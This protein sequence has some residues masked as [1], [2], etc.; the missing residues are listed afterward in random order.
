MKCLYC[1][2]NLKG[3][4]CNINGSGLVHVFEES[5]YQ[6][7]LDI[8]YNNNFDDILTFENNRVNNFWNVSIANH[9]TKI[10]L[11]KRIKLKSIK[12]INKQEID[13]IISLVMLLK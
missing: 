3:N 5:I 9:Q 7:Y 4:T 2:K 12:S 10:G 6:T 13:K 11:E 8:F 1:L